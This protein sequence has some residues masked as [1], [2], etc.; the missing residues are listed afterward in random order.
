MIRKLIAEKWHVKS[1]FILFINIS[2]VLYFHY[3]VFSTD[4]NA[5]PWYQM[6]Y[7]LIVCPIVL[8]GISYFGGFLIGIMV[9]PIFYDLMTKING[10]PF[11]IGDTVKILTNKCNGKIGTIYSLWQG[12]EFRVFIGNDY[13]DN[14]DDIFDAEMV[15][16]VHRKIAQQGDAPEPATNA[17]TASQPSI[18][19]AR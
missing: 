12:A 1:Y 15:L 13:K 6:V 5:L 17:K 18:P 14:H 3:V 4:F 2:L 19:P 10:G 11:K 7:L 16:L 8:V 9:F